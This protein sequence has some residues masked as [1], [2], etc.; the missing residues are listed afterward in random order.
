MAT[1]GFD[2]SHFRE[3]AEPFNRSEDADLA[4]CVGKSVFYTTFKHMWKL[5]KYFEQYKEHLR[6]YPRV[7]VMLDEGDCEGIVRS[8]LTFS[9]E[10]GS[11]LRC[12]GMGKA[13]RMYKVAGRYKMYKVMETLRKE[14]FANGTVI[15]SRPMSV[16]NIAYDLGLHGQARLAALVSLGIRKEVC[17]CDGEGGGDDLEYPHLNVAGQ[18]KLTLLRERRT[19]TLLAILHRANDAMY[20]RLVCSTHHGAGGMVWWP[21]WLSSA[22]AI[23]RMAPTSDVL[24]CQVHLDT[25]AS[26]LACA[27]CRWQLARA[28]EVGGQVYKLKAHMEEAEAYLNEHWMEE[29]E[30]MGKSCD[31]NIR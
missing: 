27:Q 22:E 6:E 19:N 9:S 11:A 3:A 7:V 14:V 12:C 5:T 17:I 15:L 25:V 24:N 31:A 21:A 23:I 26:V 1:I 10:S 18:R 13:G 4:I 30:E 16:Y 8:L 20:G 29:G 28:T 2:L